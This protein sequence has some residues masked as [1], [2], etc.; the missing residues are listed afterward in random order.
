M[1]RREGWHGALC[2]YI[3]AS[4]R[5]AFSYGGEGGLDCATFAAGAVQAMT[6]QDI[7]DEFRGRYASF[8]AGIRR[9]REAGFIDLADIVRAHFPEIEPAE[10]AAGDLVMVETPDGL[11]LGVAGGNRVFLLGETGLRTQPLTDARLAFRV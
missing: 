8:E 7:A 2:A 11:A 3:D 6:G 1:R 9:L 5:Q 10:A 4:R